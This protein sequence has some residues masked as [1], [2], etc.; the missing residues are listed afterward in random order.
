ME[1][2]RPAFPHR[3]RYLRLEH[4]LARRLLQAHLDWIDEVERE[5]GVP[6]RLEARGRM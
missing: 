1:A 5:L 6:D 2:A 4:S 3:E